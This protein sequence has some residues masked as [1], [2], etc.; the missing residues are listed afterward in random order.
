MA[1]DALLDHVV[2]LSLQFILD[3]LGIP[4]RADNN[5]CCARLE[6]NAVIELAAQLEWSRHP[7]S[8][9]GGSSAGMVKTSSKSRSKAL[10]KFVVATVL[11]AAYVLGVGTPRHS[12]RRSS[13]Q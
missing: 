9:E 13:C 6:V 7:Q 12:T 2:A 4:I 8:H 3:Q 11:I 5:G 1:D 10:I